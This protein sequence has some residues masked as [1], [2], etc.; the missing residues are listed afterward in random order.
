[1][2]NTEARNQRDIAIK[3]VHALVE[4]LKKPATRGNER[5]LSR[6]IGQLEVAIEDAMTKQMAYLN[7]QGASLDDEAEAE[8]V[9]YLQVTA[10]DELDDGREALHALHAQ[11][12][13]AE[14][15]ATLRRRMGDIR[16]S[17]TALEDQLS[18]EPSPA[19][20]ALC[21][22]E[23][24]KADVTM[25]TTLREFEDWI[26]L[27]TCSDRRAE[28]EK[29]RSTLRAEVSGMVLHLRTILAPIRPRAAT[30]A[31]RAASRQESPTPS[32]A[33]SGVRTKDMEFPKFEGNIRQYA[34]FKDDFKRTAEQAGI[35]DP[36][37]LSIRL[38]NESLQGE[39]RQLCLNIRDYEAV[40]RR[41]DE[42]YNHPL[43]VV[44][45]VNAQISRLKRLRDEDYDGLVNM[46]DVLERAREDLRAANQLAAIQNPH[47]CQLIE[48][49]CPDWVR[50]LWIAQRADQP[51]TGDFPALLNFLIERRGNARQLRELE[52]DDERVRPRDRAREPRRAAVNAAQ[53]R[54][55]S[56]GRRSNGGR[57]PE[58]QPSNTLGFT[59]L[60]PDCVVGSHH[61]LSRCAAW[62]GYSAAQRARV[63][64]EK[65]LC[66]L[67]FSP[68]H[69]AAEC[70]K[71][72]R[73]RPCGIGGC[74][75]WHHRS[76]HTTEAQGLTLN[77]SLGNEV[78]LLA[79]DV[80][81]EAGPAVYTLWDTGSDVS[82]IALD[83]AERL[84][85]PG[86]RC[87]FALTT[88]QGDTTQNITRAYRVRL[89]DSVG[90]VHSITAYGVPRVG[91]TFASGSVAGSGAGLKIR[92]A[93]AEMLIGMSAAH[94]QPRPFA[95]RGEYSLFTSLFGRRLLV[96][97]GGD[98]DPCN[99]DQL[100]ARNGQEPIRA[101]TNFA[102]GRGGALPP[103]TVAAVSNFVE[104]RIR[105]VDFLTTEGLGVQLPRRCRNCNN[106]YE[107]S[108]KG[109]HLSWQD[110][111]ELAMIE[112]G[113]SLDIVKK[114]W[115]SDYPFKCDPN[116]LKNNRAQAIS[117]MQSFEKRLKRNGRLEEFNQLFQE[118]IDRGIFAPVDHGDNYTGPVF[119][120][121]IVE[122]YK[123]GPGATTPIRLC[124]NS[125]LRFQGSSLNDILYTGPTALN[126]LHGVAANFRSYRVGFTKDVCKFYQSINA[127]ERV[128]QLRRVVWRWGDE[129]SSVA[130]Y[131]TKTVNFGDR[132]AGCVSMV[133]MR[134][135]A[136]L[137]AGGR[138]KA[139]EEVIR[140]SYVDDLASGAD[141][142]AEAAGLSDEIDELVAFGG[143][144]FDGRRISGEPREDA[145]SKVL[146]VLW[147]S[148]RDVLRVD[149][150]I[151]LSAKSKG[152]RELPNMTPE[153]VA[154]LPATRF[155]RR[156][157][158][159]VALAQFDLLGLLAPFFLKLKLTMRQLSGAGGNLEWDR[160][161]ADAE[162][163][164][165]IRVIA[166]IPAAGL[167]EFPRSLWPAVDAR[168][169]LLMIFADGSKV[170]S[171]ALA[172][173]RWEVNGGY[174][175]RFMGGKTRVAPLRGLTVPRMELQGAILAVRLAAHI[176][177]HVGLP[178][179][180][181]KFFTDS[182]AVL[183][184]V[185]G[186][187]ATFPEFVAARVSEIRSRS[188][189]ENW[190][191]IPT[192]CNLADLGTRGEATLEQ[193]AA[194][195]C[196]QVGQPWMNK[197]EQQWPAKR[198][199][200]C[201]P[202]EE[203]L[204]VARTMATVIG[205]ATTIDPARFSSLARAIRV[206]ALVIWTVQKWRMY[207]PSAA[208]S[209]WKPAEVLQ[210]SGD[211]RE[212]GWRWL[213]ADAQ[214]G[215]GNAMPDRH[216]RLRPVRAES[217]P[218]EVMVTGRGLETE[219]VGR[220]PRRLPLVPAGSPLAQ[221]IMRS[222]HEERHGGALKT[223]MAARKYAWIPRA[224]Q[225][226]R[227]AV[228]LCMECRRERLV[229]AEQLMA[230][231]P[232]E[233][234]EPAAAFSNIAAD[235]FGPFKIRDTVKR[236]VSREAYGLIFVCLLSTGVHLEIVDD[237]SAQSV[238]MAFRR[239][240]A[241]RGMPRSVRSD[242]GI[243][244]KAAADV[245]TRWATVAE[246]GG[247]AAPVSWTFTPPSSQ[248][249]NGSAERLIGLVKPIL[250]RLMGENLL[251]FSELSTLAMETAAI[252]NDRPLG[253][254]D[255]DAD[256]AIPLT[257][258]H[259]ISGGTAAIPVDG[260][261]EPG[262]ASRRLRFLADLKEKFWQKWTER[263]LPALLVSSK[264]N[265]GQA[266]LQ[267][268]DVV[269]LLYESKI[270]QKHR[271]GR[272]VRAPV[273]VDGKVRTVHV[274]YG[275]CS[276]NQVTHHETSRSVHRVVPL[277]TGSPQEICEG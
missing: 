3:A 101:H 206:A 93:E 131:V 67:C 229:P 103:R 14:Y 55:G 249:R 174:I 225:A 177:E 178:W 168:C 38:R 210:Q 170:A 106:C 32:R 22:E 147:D 97:G 211:N 192:D 120:V 140:R 184:M 231:L 12:Q 91:A 277:I 154:T 137:H 16:R 207:H 266:N 53:G 236:R 199:M 161:I 88:V 195:S 11:N 171:C 39:A 109:L 23:T 144:R 64:Q 65:N 84:R 159:R 36:W 87:N 235:L 265:Q 196:Y 59:C 63:V 193:L 13:S 142:F 25:N 258:N 46:V 111:K 198:N 226:A 255:A 232:P 205:P 127:S 79:E 33:S 194:G 245:I 10:V 270:G 136:K 43:R 181:V 220:D 152:V 213:V 90:V 134:E 228:G 37:L 115:T 241:V 251:T 95:R 150:K 173:V 214:K 80:H 21:E 138:E 77:V 269:I 76:L 180:G 227:R 156:V 34:T 56:A 126:D 183:G 202:P 52:D 85:L 116:I 99:A 230:R 222:A 24:D 107:C 149:T 250:K 100:P 200:G 175:C 158:W 143:F 89:L 7:R 247:L 169:P 218:Q 112:Q 47:T 18:A 5:Q 165:F 26:L 75:E 49:K 172:Y 224:G 74:A 246:S 122:A 219:A 153:E 187:A 185:T 92:R 73:W 125:S 259:L 72:G 130:T 190:M 188:A 44:A 28:M 66:K 60:A 243:Q 61:Y 203:R 113:L 118:S 35:T 31:G 139:A 233:R 263:V 262:W 121:S 30:F 244:L 221:L 82:L 252:V 96:G 19:I 42:V 186:D 15:L 40:W 124:L 133:A 272:I 41:L 261:A 68:H 128:Q 69:Q 114:K 17:L 242:R 276:G 1:M 204:K 257:P 50:R 2:T 4:K 78:L 216:S 105:P 151:N 264:W 129:T 271:L 119:Y 201:V 268:G 182:S 98:G 238:V 102:S 239:F 215:A 104:G 9:D 162:R 86:S 248:H 146:G 164:T 157:V 256:V 83:L 237:Y 253:C 123:T 148:V 71:R 240:A 209:R 274:R 70:P 197:P 176:Q 273:D 29:V 6:V 58:D 267:E 110:N 254:T 217:W 167:I 48:K 54:A 141:T 145:W 45:E 208:G 163:E 166:D 160:P 179:T 234:T 62:T 155:T 108:F 135:T 260:G 20:V 212:S 223:A 8:V 57:S 81:L 27:V 94:L 191:W 132:P 51:D 189:E 275:V 117:L